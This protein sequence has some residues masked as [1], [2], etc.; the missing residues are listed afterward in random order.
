[1]LLLTLHQLV[2]LTWRLTKRNFH[3]P[4]SCSSKKKERNSAL[5]CQKA[6]TKNKFKSKKAAGCYFWL[7]VC[8]FGNG[9]RNVCVWTLT[10]SCVNSRLLPNTDWH[11]MRWKQPT[12]KPF[13]AWKR[14]LPKSQHTLNILVLFF[15]ILLIIIWSSNAGKLRLFHYCL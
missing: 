3:F 13:Q 4:H 6:E 8:S 1:M 12:W 15:C 5:K 11:F 2:S 14:M 9:R 7:W 10:E